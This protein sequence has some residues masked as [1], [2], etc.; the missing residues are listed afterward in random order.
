VCYLCGLCHID[1]K[2]ML[3]S[4]FDRKKRA[5]PDVTVILT[6]CGR[7]DLLERTLSS[8]V[9]HNTYAAI[10]EFIVVEDGVGDPSEICGK[11]GARLIRIGERRGQI[12]AIDTAYAQVKTPYIFHLEDDWLFYKPGFIERSRQILEADPSTLQV[13]LRAWDD[14]NGH[15]LVFKAD[16]GSFATVATG[17]LKVWNGFSFNPGL[18]RF[19]DY[20]KI[21]SY[22]AA[23]INGLHF[24]EAISVKYGELGYRAVILDRDGYVEHIGWDRHVE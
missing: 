3:L 4:L 20:R 16:D 21:G 6:S 7:H 12:H 13:W 22:A 14:T 2:I 19:S 23:A 1:N 18:R 11:F 24:E 8:F 9:K 10:A 17:V 15:P 5:T